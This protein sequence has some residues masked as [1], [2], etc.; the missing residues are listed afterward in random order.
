MRRKKWAMKVCSSFS[1]KC[2]P[3]KS[4]LALAVTSAASFLISSFSGAVGPGVVP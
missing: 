2:T 4:P 3:A 1:R